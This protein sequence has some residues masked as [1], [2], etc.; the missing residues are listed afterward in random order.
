MRAEGSIDIA[1]ESVRDRK[2]GVRF[3]CVVGVDKVITFVYNRS[4]KRGL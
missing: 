2:R 4:E 1:R 3:F